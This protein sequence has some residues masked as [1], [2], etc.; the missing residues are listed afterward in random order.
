MELESKHNATQQRKNEFVKWSL[1]AVDGRR[2][3]YNP[4]FHF[5]NTTQNQLKLILFCFLIHE[6]YEWIKKYY[7]S[8]FNLDF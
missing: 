8:K 1:G 2:A 7:N 6:I 4:Q 5:I 3:A